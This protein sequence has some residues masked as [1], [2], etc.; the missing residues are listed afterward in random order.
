M[1]SF[2]TYNPNNLVKTLICGESGSGKT[3]LL[4]TL[5]KAKFI[6]KIIILDFDNGLRILKSYLDEEQTKKIIFETLDPMDPKSA[7]T[8]A[9]LA[10]QWKT[11]SEDLGHY[12]SWNAQTVFVVDSL[13]F[14]GNAFLANAEAEMKARRDPRMNHRQAIIGEAQQGL[15]KFVAHCFF[16]MPC[17]VIF[18]THIKGTE[19]GGA[20]RNYPSTI[21]VALS[22]KVGRYV[23]DMWRIDV[24]PGDKRIIRTTADHNMT[25]K[26]SAPNVLKPEE[27]FNLEKIFATL[28]VT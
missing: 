7:V 1:P 23:N 28:M 15:E 16:R 20:M 27:D 17:H 25:L 11:K 14:A 22:Q 3:G 13:T 10:M 26:N 9:S 21:G 2:Q 5:A 12:T 4:A 6:D 24:K 19:E 8:A 18:N